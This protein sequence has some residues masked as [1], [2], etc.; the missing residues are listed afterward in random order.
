MEEVRKHKRGREM[1]VG[2][3]SHYYSHTSTVYIGSPPPL[4]WGIS[5]HRRVS[6]HNMDVLRPNEP[7]HRNI[8]S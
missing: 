5:S 2:G 3:R 1:R 6:I 7:P 4:A 8:P